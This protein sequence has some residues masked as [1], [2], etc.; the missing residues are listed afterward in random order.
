MDFFLQNIFSRDGHLAAFVHL[1]PREPQ[2]ADRC[3]QETTSLEAG[4][5][6]EPD[7]EPGVPGVSLN[8]TVF[9]DHTPGRS[10]PRGDTIHYFFFLCV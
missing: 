7:P 3:H 10:D 1:V 8:A 2:P 6:L 5:S 9:C 4:F